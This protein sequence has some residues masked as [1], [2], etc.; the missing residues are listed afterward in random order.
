M[1]ARLPI[2]LSYSPILY[3]FIKRRASL[4]WVGFLLSKPVE[5]S[6]NMLH[7]LREKLF[8]NWILNGKD[9][10]WSSIFCKGRG[11][12]VDSFYLSAL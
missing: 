2:Q 5:T 8:E 4:G 10:L 11:C 6:A 1:D 7:Q 3:M 12:L 9:V